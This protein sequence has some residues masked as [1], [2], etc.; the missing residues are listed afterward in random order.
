MCNYYS[1]VF[2]VLLS[3]VTHKLL[4]TG[5]KAME[6]YD[7]I[8]QIYNGNFLLAHVDR[9]DFP[10]GWQA[11]GGDSSTTWKWLG[12]PGGP[13]AMQ[14]NHPSGPRA[15]IL[16]SIDVPILAGNNQR[17]E[18]QLLIQSNS[19]D[20]LCYIKV[21]L[22][23]VAQ[24]V[25]I[26][27]AM[28]EKKLV[29]KVFTTSPGTGGMR[30]EVGI[31]GN[32]DLILHE[33]RAYRLYPLR[34]LK[35]D[36]QGQVYVQHVES[37]GKIQSIVPV[38]VVHPLPL[39]IDFRASI[40]ADIRSLTPHSDGVRIYDSHANTIGST[41]EGAL[42]VQLSSRRLVATEENVLAGVVELYTASTDISELTTYS[43][44]IKNR[45]PSSAWVHLELSPDGVNWV[46]DNQEVELASGQLQILV[47]QF[48]LR[49]IRVAYRALN[50]I[51]L[52]IWLQAQC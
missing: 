36:E 43:Y 32:G 3:R 25:S 18:F 21:Y 13:R 4:Y 34:S 50:S 48:F 1:P 27:Y 35:L 10:D 12:S 11:K 22:G 37:I 31:I 46:A 19:A 44:A 39:P 15:G 40:T 2:G 33:L 42:K 23:S 51:P 30:V 14:I 45:G 20:T 49:Y 7:L 17:W 41:P 16:Q 5:G 52:T 28:E 47:P 24:R 38:Q 8:D 9:P 29:N 26:F 6:E